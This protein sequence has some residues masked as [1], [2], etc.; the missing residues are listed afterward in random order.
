MNTSSIVN[1]GVI[2]LNIVF[3]VAKEIN[4]IIVT[5]IPASTNTVI[6]DAIVQAIFIVLLIVSCTNSNFF[7]FCSFSIRFLVYASCKELTKFHKANL[8]NGLEI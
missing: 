1:F 4:L 7:I 3:K 5:L 6:F 8:T 2:K